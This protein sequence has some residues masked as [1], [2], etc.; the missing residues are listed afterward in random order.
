MFR[1]CEY[2][3]CQKIRTKPASKTFSE[4]L[5]VQFRAPISTATTKAAQSPASIET[6]RINRKNAMYGANPKRIFMSY[7]FLSPYLPFS[8][9]E[10][11]SVTRPPGGCTAD[12][13]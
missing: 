11:I 9:Q 6:V 13:F 7:P 5:R 8:I 4:P 1:C 12:T 10:K 2:D 3:Q